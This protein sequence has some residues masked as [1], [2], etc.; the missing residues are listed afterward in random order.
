VVLVVEF[1]A[2]TGLGWG[3]LLAELIKGR[4]RVLFVSYGG[5]GAFL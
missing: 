3:V 4:S 1:I 2:E 5:K